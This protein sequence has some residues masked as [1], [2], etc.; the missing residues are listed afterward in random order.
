MISP[1]VG[2]W[3]DGGSPVTI[4]FTRTG[5]VIV[6]NQD[7]VITGKYELIGSDVIKLRFEGLPGGLLMLFGGDS[8]QYEISGDIMTVRAAGKVSK[9]TRVGGGDLNNIFAPLIEAVKNLPNIIPSPVSVTNNPPANP[10]PSAQAAQPATS[11]ITSIYPNGGEHWQVGDAVIIKWTSVNIPASAP[12]EIIL[13]DA[14][15]GRG[16]TIGTTTN[17]G[18]FSW[19]VTNQIIGDKVRLNLRISPYYVSL[20]SIG[21]FTI[22]NN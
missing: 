15:T 13:E 3:K 6:F 2:K 8:W 7:Y 20:R 9:L 16:I 18:T 21:N 5:D 1:V 17:T 12:V 14:S 4:E 10:S 19:R 22:S 11:K